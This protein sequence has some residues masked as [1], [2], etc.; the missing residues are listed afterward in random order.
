MSSNRGFYLVFFK[1]KLFV[2]VKDWIFF[3]FVGGLKGIGVK[4]W[5]EGGGVGGFC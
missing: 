1:E 5:K 4:C 3:L 2:G